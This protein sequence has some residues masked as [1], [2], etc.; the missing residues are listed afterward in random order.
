[1]F[2]GLIG[3]SS[4]VE[5]HLSCSNITQLLIVLFVELRPGGLFPFFVVFISI[6]L[7]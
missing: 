5:D 2:L 3:C 1:M 6:V 7:V 4:L